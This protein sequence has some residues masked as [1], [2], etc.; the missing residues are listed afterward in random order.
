VGYEFDIFLSYTRASSNGQWVME[1]FRTLLQERLDNAMPREPKMFVFEDQESATAWPENLA[2]ALRRSR[3]LVAVLSPPYF[4]SRWCI[5][6]WESM[7]ARERECGLGTED[8]ARR[9]IHPLIYADGKHFPE[10]ARRNFSRDFS[11]WNYPYPHFRDTPAY[12]RFFDAVDILANE[13]AGRLDDVPEWRADFP[14]V[15]PTPGAAV[16]V[17]LERL[18]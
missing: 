9:L 13:I 2:F 10:D 6:E 5:A 16:A 1:H 8:N 14:I 15:R 18:V 17:E 4:R 3:V 11:S 7:V 12:L